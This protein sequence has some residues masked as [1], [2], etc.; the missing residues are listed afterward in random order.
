M[1]ST[2]AV[3]PPEVCP[4][5]V[6]R[7]TCFTKP[8]TFPAST[9]GWRECID[10]DGNKLWVNDFS[11]LSTQSH[12]PSD[13]VL[14]PWSWHTPL[15]WIEGASSLRPTTPTKFPRLVRVRWSLDRNVMLPSAVA[16]YVW[17]LEM[18]QLAEQLEQWHISSPPTH[19]RSRWVPLDRPTT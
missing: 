9:W 13:P 5:S 14:R 4:A 2:L 15:G 12:I 1:E 17:D 11:E 3:T 19:Q 7:E 8:P 6:A 18:D 10:S 16:D